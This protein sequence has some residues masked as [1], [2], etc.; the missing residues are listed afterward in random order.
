MF[1]PLVGTI[2]HAEPEE[3][4]RNVLTSSDDLCMVT[5]METATAY[6]VT[7]APKFAGMM[8]PDCHACGHP[9]L[10][11]PVWVTNGAAVMALGSGCAAKLVGGDAELAALMLDA[12]D[13]T[14]RNAVNWLRCF[15]PARITARLRADIAERYYNRVDVDE[16][17][18]IYKLGK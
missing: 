2:W 3:T 8:T 14:T 9:E 15:Q 10:G 5:Y 12:A 16:V 1:A 7:D 4:S 18:Q 11:R 17:C 6:R 13:D